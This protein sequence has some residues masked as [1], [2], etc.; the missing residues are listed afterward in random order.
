VHWVSLVQLAAHL[1]PDPHMYG[2]HGELVA[3]QT[4]VSHVPATV[5]FDVP[6]G[7]DSAEQTVDAA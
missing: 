6:A 3:L 5:W 2:S 7:H 1:P 4:P